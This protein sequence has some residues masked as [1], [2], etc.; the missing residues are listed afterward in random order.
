MITSNNYSAFIV[1]AEGESP[2]KIKVFRNI[3]TWGVDRSTN[4]HQWY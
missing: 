1:T 2:D 4:P 3:N